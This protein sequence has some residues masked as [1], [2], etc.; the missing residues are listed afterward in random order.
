M[1]FFA[2]SGAGGKAEG[3]KTAKS[4]ENDRDDDPGQKSCGHHCGHLN[5]R[6]IFFD[7]WFVTHFRCLNLNQHR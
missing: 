1:E 6:W 3:L 5:M 4:K 2:T 7:V